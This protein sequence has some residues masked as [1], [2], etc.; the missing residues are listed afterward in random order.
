[1]A[2]S[3]VGL[4]KRHLMLSLAPIADAFSGT[5]TSDVHNVKGQGILFTVFWGVGATGTVTFTALAADDTTPSNTTAVP[6]TYRSSTTN[7][8]WG[9]WTAATTAG[10][11]TTAGSNQ[12]HQIYVDAAE[13]AEEGYGYCQLQ[14][15]EVADSPI[16]GGIL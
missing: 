12:M 16:L 9:N 14:G 7:D 6:F 4:D 2:Y 11:T 5:S 13:L 3:N 1:M 8:T 10:F 15:V